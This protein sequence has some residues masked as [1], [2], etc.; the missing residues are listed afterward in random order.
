M[1]L[2][3]NLMFRIMLADLLHLFCR[4]GAP[5]A[6][7]INGFAEFFLFVEVRLK[8]ITKNKAPNK[9]CHNR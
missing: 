8:R 1:H 9:H 2:C 7:T 6:D 5:F 4:I 3:Y